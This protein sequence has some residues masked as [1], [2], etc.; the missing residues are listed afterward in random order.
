MDAERNHFLRGV[1][2]D[3]KLKQPV[4]NYSSERASRSKLQSL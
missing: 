4:Q 1:L 2:L 3:L